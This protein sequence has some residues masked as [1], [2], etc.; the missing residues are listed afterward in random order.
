MVGAHHRGAPGRVLR[1]HDVAAGD[2]R[3]RPGC[4]DDGGQGWAGRRG[5][6]D[7]RAVAAPWGSPRGSRG[8]VLRPVVGVDTVVERVGPEVSRGASG[9][10]VRGGKCV[11]VPRLSAPRGRATFGRG[12]CEVGLVGDGGV[13]CAA[14]G[15]RG[16]D[17]SS[18][19]PAGGVAAAAGVTGGGLRQPQ[20]LR[21]GADG[22][23]GPGVRG[24]G[25][26]DVVGSAFGVVAVRRDV[27]VAAVVDVQSGC[28][29]GLVR[30]RGDRG[31]GRRAAS[32]GASAWAL[33]GVTGGGDRGG[34][35]R[36]GACLRAGGAGG[37]SGVPVARSW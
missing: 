21:G 32:G 37:E 4:R 5:S 14:G 13:H 28:G 23:P 27:C 11:D 18:P 1:L 36:G 15:V 30:L 8:G 31:G 22:G 9:A 16:G 3:G 10:A 34:C 25:G 12:G 29:G 7:A 17:A 24:G 2:G 20:Q 19:R 35:D 6:G 33:V 26:A